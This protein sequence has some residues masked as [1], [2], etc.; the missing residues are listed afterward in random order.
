MASVKQIRLTT[1][2]AGHCPVCFE[3][4]MA[5]ETE[6]QVRV[7]DSVRIVVDGTVCAV[8]CPPSNNNLPPLCY[9]GFETKLSPAASF[10]SGNQGENNV[11]KQTEVANSGIVFGSN[12]QCRASSETLPTDGANPGAA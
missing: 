12:D 5:V 1:F 9:V 4:T 8:D 3:G 10:T 2:A 6:N 11:E 7:G